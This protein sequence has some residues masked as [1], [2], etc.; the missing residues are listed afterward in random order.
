[1][2]RHFDL[3]AVRLDVPAHARWHCPSRLSRPA[4][5]PSLPAPDF[6]H[7]HREKLFPAISIVLDRGGIHVEKAQALAVIDPHRD[8]LL[9]NI[10]RNDDSRCLSSVMSLCVITQPP[11]GFG[12]ISIKMIR[13]SASLASARPPFAAD[14]SGALVRI[15]IE[16][17]GGE[18]LCAGDH[19]SRCPVS[20]CLRTGGT[21]RGTDH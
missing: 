20:P 9:S 3:R 19:A 16:C 1:M 7:R 21:C 4:A 5:P 14:E 8:R 11:P 17:P 6:Q 2:D 13:P 15:A 18:P 10:R 12:L